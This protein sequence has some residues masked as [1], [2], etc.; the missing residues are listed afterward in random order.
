MSRPS[1]ATANSHSEESRGVRQW[2]RRVSLQL[3]L[4]L[5]AGTLGGC[6]RTPDS[7]ELVRPAPPPAAESRP[8]PPANPAV[9]PR[10]TRIA[11]RPAPAESAPPPPPPDTWERLRRRFSLV[12]A[13]HPRIDRE[14]E[15]LRRHPL[16]LQALL[17]RGT[18]YLRHFLDAVESR[19]MPGEL[20][21]L[22]A[23]ES[24]FDPWAYSPGGAAGLWQ[25]MPAT[26]QM[27]GL[28]RDRWYD[29][30]LDLARAT[31][32]ALDYLQ[33][34]QRRLDGN[35]LH[36]LAAYN[37]GIGTV[38]KALR[39]ARRKGG[40][41]SYWD[42][43][44]PGETDA[45]VPRLL[46]LARIV[47]DPARYGVTLPPA[48]DDGL[49]PVPVNASLDLEVAARLAG[50]ELERLLR[51]NP[52][53]RRGVTPPGR[54]SLLLLPAAR[55]ETFRIALDALPRDQWLRWTE[56][57]I[58]RGDTLGGIAR[59]YGV[60]IAAVREANGLK[61]SRIVAGR[62]LRIP[63]SGKAAAASRNVAAGRRKVRYRVRKGDS[64][65]TIARKFSVSIRDL[66]RWNR[67]GRYLRPGQRLTV[68]VKA[69]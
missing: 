65:Y 26:A 24:G 63:L 2:R 20:A 11:E 29:G 45:Y 13:Q 67:V 35:W 69:G 51:L 52:G 23:V 31:P 54:R 49:V 21:L 10:H 40:S 7:P 64:L 60:S 27:L 38:R 12:E 42:L 53:F 3:A 6:F 62:T 30:R 9:P 56:H 66:R 4:I 36:A 32:T 33:N 14:L 58:A 48:G 41:T 61:G 47:Q 46:A 28:R 39:Q 18:P 59:R 1:A 68:Y 44:L 19:D 16:S 34:L 57:R 15:R 8:E 50:M 22:P 25:F 43:E 37:C 55:A 5:L 17:R